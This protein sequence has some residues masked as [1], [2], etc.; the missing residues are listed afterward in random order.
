MGRLRKSLERHLDEDE[1]DRAIET[2]QRRGDARLV[3]RLCLVASLYAGD[4]LSEA[5]RRV[6]VSQPTAGRWADRWN[7]D[8]VDG[9]RPSFGGGRPSR[10]GDAELQRVRAMLDGDEP[11]TA[12]EL[13]SLLESE[14]GVSYSRRHA[15]RLVAQLDRDP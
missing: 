8:G 14:F 12:S 5:G 13:Q 9:L 7:R 4:T 1:L 10:L 6:G 11:A 3:R 15:S 2:A